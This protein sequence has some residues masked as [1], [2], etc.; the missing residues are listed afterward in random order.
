MSDGWARVIQHNKWIARIHHAVAVDSSSYL[1]TSNEDKGCLLAYYADLMDDAF[2]DYEASSEYYEKAIQLDPNGAWI[3][4]NWAMLLDKKL[5]VVEKA[6]EMY[7]KAYNME[8]NNPNILCNFAVFLDETKE[9]YDRAEQL[10][11]R[12]LAVDPED[13]HVIHALI[14]FLLFK[15]RN[16]YE[17]RDLFKNAKLQPA[18]STDGRDL[19]VVVQY[20]ECLTYIQHEYDEASVV[21]QQIHHQIQRHGWNQQSKEYKRMVFLALLQYSVFLVYTN[22]S[23]TEAVEILSQALALESVDDDTL[24]HHTAFAIALVLK[25]YNAVVA[26]ESS[27]FDLICL[28][29]LYR[30]IHQGQTKEAANMWLR[31]IKHMPSKAQSFPKYCVGVFLRI[32]GRNR[33]LSCQFISQAFKDDA[34]Y[35][36]YQ[37]LDFLLREYAKKA[38]KNKSIAKV[39]QTMLTEFYFAEQYHASS[40]N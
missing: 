26:M 29:A 30:Y 14:D 39:M 25:D 35:L 15:R 34:F 1:L 4:H 5:N 23:R 18:A 33:P 10:Y 40:K 3:A 37:K 32:H 17:A 13:L 9:D 27:N 8:P 21:F 22:R 6:A 28:V 7:E 11:R 38:T 31:A 16:I 24:K 2:G 12:A 20:A 36:Q 19:K